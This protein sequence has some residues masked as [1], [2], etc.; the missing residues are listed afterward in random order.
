MAEQTPGPGWVPSACTLP[1]AEQPLRLAEFDALFATAVRTVER[2]T[3]THLRLTMTGEPDLAATV[4]DLAAREG[5]C[6]S[7]FTFAVSS[8]A[9]GQVTLDI[10]VPPAHADVL[11]ALEQ[12]A[13][14]VREHS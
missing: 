3:D 2:V 7:F 14:T 9:P 13:H 8:P 6:C 5:D 4:R 1:T 10:E 12:R 11:A